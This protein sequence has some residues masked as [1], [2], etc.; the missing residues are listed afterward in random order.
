MPDPARHFETERTMNPRTALDEKV[1]H[2]QSDVEELKSD[3]RE[4]RTKIDAVSADLAEHRVE[5]ERSFGALRAEMA[6]GFGAVRAEMAAGL[7]ALEGKMKD[8][9]AK[10]MSARAADRVW[11]L[12]IA[13]TLLGVMARG[14]KW[15]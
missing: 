11:W 2:I 10:V 7:G 9:I 4:L 8:E 1:D 15:I 14:F 6:A 3:V 13:G 12:V 5:T